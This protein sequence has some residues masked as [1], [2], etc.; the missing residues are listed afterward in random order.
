MQIQKAS[1]RGFRSLWDV[2]ISD[3]GG[4]NILY[5][6]NNCGKSNVLGALQLLFRVEKAEELVPFCNVLKEPGHSLR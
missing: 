3:L 5:G 1:I 2:S 6:D 4:V